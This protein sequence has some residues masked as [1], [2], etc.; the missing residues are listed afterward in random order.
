[1]QYARWA[2]KNELMDRLVP[3]DVK[4]EV[5]V[6][7]TPIM[8]DNDTL[9]VDKYKAHTL[10]I[11]AS[12]C[13]KTQTTILPMIRLAIKAQESFFVNDPK[14]ELY[15]R[16]AKKLEEENY[17]RIVIDL[18]N[19]TLGNNWN[20]LLFPY[21]IY[22]EGNVDKA[23]E[24][25]ED[26]AYYLFVDEKETNNDPFWI[27]STVDFFT[28]LVLYLFENA[29]EEEI[30]FASVMR[31][32]QYINDDGNRI[33]FMNKLD[34]Q[35][36]AYLNL[37]TTLNAPAETRGSILAVFNQKIKLFVSRQNLSNLLANNDFSFH[38]VNNKKTAIFVIG[39]TSESSGR[40]IP[41][42]ISQL[43]ES[44]DLYS[45]NKKQFNILLDEFDS[46]VEIKNFS[47]LLARARGLYIQFTVVI[48]SYIH[49]IN[50]YGKEN[51]ELLKLCFG[52]ILYL[53]S[54]DIYTLTEISKMC[55]EVGK[56]QD[57]ITVEELKTMKQFEMIGLM[58]RVYPYK[59]KLVPDYLIDWGYELE[60]AEIPKREVK[61]INIVEI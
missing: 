36:A 46:M 41:L 13:G 11:G 28:G 14:G 55:G 53:L 29:K 25:I 18:E 49:L 61:T 5:E 4:G 33:I 30:H 58:P 44:V 47:K 24:L 56:N 9:Y 57:L 26:V 21:E 31:L 60:D 8:Y 51:T 40:L 22:Q 16:M 17:Q 50:I 10:L 19:T 20:P 3:V 59:T 39:G 32:V 38:D 34:R 42:Y 1:M 37:A 54:N 35:S 45:K 23:Q 52:N 2:T 27:N 6:S 15:K 7:G 48:Q 43:V 12:G